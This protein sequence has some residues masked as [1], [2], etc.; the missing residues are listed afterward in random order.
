MSSSIPALFHDA[1]K[2]LGGTGTAGTL[3]RITVQQVLH[4]TSLI[5]VE[6]PPSG[7]PCVHTATSTQ[8]CGL[9]TPL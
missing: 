7:D 9:N 4:H 2:L 1:V 6:S 5:K 3:T 8:P